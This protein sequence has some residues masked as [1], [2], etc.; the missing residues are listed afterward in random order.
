MSRVSCL[1]V[2]SVAWVV[3]AMGVSLGAEPSGQA[4]PKPRASTRRVPIIHSTDLFHPHADP[5]DHYDL[6]TL[7]AIDEFDVRGIILD[8]GATQAER[9]GRPAVEQMMHLARRTCPVALGL[10]R[11]LRTRTDRG[12]DDPEEFQAGVRLILSVLRAS[13]DK[14]VLHTAGSCRDV[15][16]AFNRQPELLQK[17]VLAVYFNIGRG[18]NEPQEECNVGYDPTAYLRMFESGLPLYWC[19]CFGNEGYETRYTV[20]QTTVVGACR[21][22]VR[23]FFVYCLTKSTADPIAFLASGPYPLP[24]G[25]RAMWCTAPLFHAAGRKVYQRGPNDFVALQPAAAEQAGLKEKEVAAFR[26]VPMRATIEATAPAIARRPARPGAL[27][28]LWQGQRDDRVGTGRPEPDGRPDCGVRVVGVHPERTIQNLILTGPKQG[29]WEYVET[30]RWWRVAFQRHGTQLDAW[31]QFYAPGEHQ[32][33]IVYADGTRQIARF[34][35]PNVGPAALR[36]EV[37]PTEPNGLVFRAIDPRYPQI[38]ASCLK[39]L[40]AELGR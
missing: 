5:D 8:L 17:K 15:A 26:F 36:V 22:A 27:G 32:I 13:D 19:P 6:A 14:V 10:R 30:G 24:R 3:S 20:D 9:S 31:F 40:L 1:A 25:P 39:N 7:F 16:A 12:D 28:A 38:M 29:R 21:P 11:P 33:E 2:A 35:V 18:P 34:E 23:N 37:D 4:G